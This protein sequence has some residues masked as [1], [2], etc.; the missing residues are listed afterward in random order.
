MFNPFKIYKYYKDSQ[1]KGPLL[2]QLVTKQK[3]LLQEQKRYQSDPKKIVES[4][5]HKGIEWYNYEEQAKELHKKYFDEAQMIL[6]SNVFN[7]EKNYLVATGAEHALLESLTP[8][9]LRDFQMTINGLELLQTR[10]EEIKDPTK[11]ESKN[12]IHA[13]V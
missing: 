7:N 9:Q 8:Q 13:G 3:E 4:C 5:F 6:N 2:E 12:D 10:L 11:E 1:E